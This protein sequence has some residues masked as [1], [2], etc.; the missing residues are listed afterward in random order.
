LRGLRHGGAEAAVGTR[1]TGR[2]T[3]LRIP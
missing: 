1:V 3:E 2:W